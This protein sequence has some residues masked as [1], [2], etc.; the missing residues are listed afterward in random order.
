MGDQWGLRLLEVISDAGLCVRADEDLI[1]P[2]HTGMVLTDI[3][4]ELLTLGTVIRGGMHV[5]CH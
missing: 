1:S 4:P 5:Q 2:T 3:L